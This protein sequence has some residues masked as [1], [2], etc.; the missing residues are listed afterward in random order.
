MSTIISKTVRFNLDLPEE[1]AAYEAVKKAGT[2]SGN[3][4]VIV[5]INE[6]VK[7]NEKNEDCK[8]LLEAVRQVVQ[9]EITRAV[10]QLSGNK[11][12]RVDK[13]EFKDELESLP[14]LLD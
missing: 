14:P 3:R 11:R 1:A 8:Q 4:F 7:E 6:Y 9:E 2:G 10:L 12:Q 13:D 5:A